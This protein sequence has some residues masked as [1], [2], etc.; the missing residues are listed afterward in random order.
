MMNPTNPPPPIQVQVRELET[1]FWTVGLLGLAARLLGVN[2]RPAAPAPKLGLRSRH[3]C[4]VLEISGDGDYAGT[5][6][7]SFAGELR[8]RVLRGQGS[9]SLEVAA[10]HLALRLQCTSRQPIWL[11]VRRGDEVVEHRQLTCYSGHFV[12]IQGQTRNH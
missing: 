6:E 9:R 1:T 7:T 4:F 2:P 5:L 3:H 10:S 12:L 8:Q 11:T